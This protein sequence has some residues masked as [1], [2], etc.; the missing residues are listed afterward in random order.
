MAGTTLLLVGVVLVVVVVFTSSYRVSYL[1][2]DNYKSLNS[3][4]HYYGMFGLLSTG[5][6][7]LIIYLLWWL[8]IPFYFEAIVVKDL[9]NSLGI[10]PDENIS[11]LVGQVETI[12][13]TF[14]F[15]RSLKKIGGI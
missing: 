4:I 13:D 5:L 15:C 7:V 10:S 12:R 14:F 1:V 11:L 9:V 6:P 8:L 2:R 3:R